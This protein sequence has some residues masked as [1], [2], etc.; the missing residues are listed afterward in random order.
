MAGFSHA[1]SGLVF[2]KGEYHL[3]YQFNP[4]TTHWAAPHW[5]HA[6]STDLAHWH[7]L[8]I[9]LAPDD[10]GYIFSG[11]AVHDHTSRHDLTAIFTHAGPR[12]QVQ[13]LAFSS[14]RGRTWTKYAANPV[15]APP[16]EAPRPD[17]RD[18]KVRWHAESG[19]WVMVLAVGDRVHFYV[20]ADLTSWR[21]ASEFGADAGFHSGS[22]WEC[23]DLF[24]VRHAGATHWVLLVSVN[25]GGPNG[26]SGTQYFVGGFNG[27]HFV[28]A[29]PPDAVRWLDYGRDDYAGVTFAHAPE[30]RVLFIG[31]LSN[32]A[33]ANTVRRHSVRTRRS[34]RTVKVPLC[35]PLKR[36]ASAPTAT[37]DPDSRL[38]CRARY[39]A[40]ACRCRRP[41]GAPQ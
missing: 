3:F 31:W 17:F 23:P 41:A 4:T 25:S 13:S 15:L 10:L 32:W 20:A 11:S 6:V 14:D 28:S 29:S 2:F 35:T 16:A 40:C 19:S 5:G 24:P 22:T 26:G 18:P 38:R 7:D 8:P 27:S 12:G 34:L 21:L 30:G 37:A 36:G 33:Y 9:A 1:R 39:R